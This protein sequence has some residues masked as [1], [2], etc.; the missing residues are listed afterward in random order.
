M[1]AG[2]NEYA[3]LTKPHRNASPACTVYSARYAQAALDGSLVLDRQSRPRDL[4]ADGDPEVVQVVLPP[5]DLQVF[6]CAPKEAKGPRAAYLSSCAAQ[7]Q[8][9]TASKHKC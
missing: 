3:L 1:Q 8:Q 6:A 2:H 7:R 4:V 9:G 5:K